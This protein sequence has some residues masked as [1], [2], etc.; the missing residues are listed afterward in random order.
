[1][2]RPATIVMFLLAAVSEPAD[3][4]GSRMR[5]GL[6]IGIPQ[7]A[8]FTFEIPHDS[9]LRFQGNVGVGPAFA[10]TG[11]AV[12]ARRGGRLK[13]YAFAGAGVLGIAWQAG[14]IAGAAVV[15]VLWAGG[16]LR[17]PFG[18][19][20]LFGELGVLGDSGLESDVGAAAVGIL[21]PIQEEVTR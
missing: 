10:V 20:E 4:A 13:P 9:L 21:F 12:V 6:V 2:L 7:M 14:D 5:G 19:A 3:A 18:T 17:V 11:R 1:M 8:A 15:P 16:G